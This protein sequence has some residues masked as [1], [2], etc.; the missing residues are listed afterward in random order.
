MKARGTPP[1][2]RGL[3][4]EIDRLYQLPL[5]EF[6]GARNELAKQPGK[7]GAEIK[8][9]AK[10]P[11][12]AWGVNQLYW[13]RRPEYDALVDAAQELRRA[14]AAV[15]AGKAG[16]T[17]RS[18]RHVRY[19]R[20]TPLCNLY[21]EMLDRMGCRPERFGDSTGRLAQLT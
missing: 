9:L 2:S 18:G 7:R 4:A 17:I 12:A 21:L 5:A 6:T 8:A 19:S 15:L 14:H 11:V 10:P 16:G 3:D 20:N 1:E 13:H